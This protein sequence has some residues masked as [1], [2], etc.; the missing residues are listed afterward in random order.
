MYGLDSLFIL[1]QSDLAKLSDEEGLWCSVEYTP[2]LK[3]LLGW[4]KILYDIF[5][6]DNC[7]LFLLIQWIKTDVWEKKLK[8]FLFH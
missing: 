1:S 2:F 6:D 4:T 3:G 5:K 8:K 7:I